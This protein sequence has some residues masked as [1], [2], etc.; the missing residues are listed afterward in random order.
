MS[1]LY[2]SKLCSL[3]IDSTYIAE[4]TMSIAMQHSLLI[5]I[6]DIFECIL[7]VKKNIS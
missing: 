3:T 1:S 4:N 6:F 2:M 5:L 7:E